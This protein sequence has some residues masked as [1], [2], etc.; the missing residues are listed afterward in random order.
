[1]AE[2]SFLEK[3]QENS[4]LM[5]SVP[6][7]ALLLANSQ[8]SVQKEIE[9]FAVRIP[10][11]A[12]PSYKTEFLYQTRTASTIALF[13]ASSLFKYTDARPTVFLHYYATSISLHQ[14]R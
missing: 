11:F 13:L 4:P 14:I 9:S 8:F 10:I 6:R 2:T 3:M 5:I 12:Y 7:L 1:M